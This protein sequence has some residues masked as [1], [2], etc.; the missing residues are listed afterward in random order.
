MTRKLILSVTKKDID[1]S[2]FSG[3]GPGGQNRNRN[4]CCCR[5]YH[6]DSGA[7]AT[8]QDSKNKPINMKNC[9]IR[10]INT[11]EFKLWE[12]MEVSRRMLNESDIEDTVDKQMHR[13]NL[14]YEIR[15]EDGN[16]I[17]VEPEL[18]GAEE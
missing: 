4:M 8:G 13:R 9:F 17:E 12:R 18:L 14:K 3:K 11:E 16:W 6:R 10:L 7:K 5:M 15:N 2:F 1:I